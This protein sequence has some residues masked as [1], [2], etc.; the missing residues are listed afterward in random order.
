MQLFSVSNRCC[1]EPVSLSRYIYV[2]IYTVAQARETK[3]KQYDMGVG[4][5]NEIHR[6]ESSSV[7]LEFKRRA[8]QPLALK[9]YR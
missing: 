9:S 1:F 6:V 8:K 5:I 3:G 2:Y 4:K 7:R